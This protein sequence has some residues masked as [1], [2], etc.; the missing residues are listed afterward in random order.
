MNRG[1]D[2][3]R[4]FSDKESVKMVKKRKKTLILDEQFNDKPIFFQ[5]Q[6]I[7]LANKKRLENAIER[8][9]KIIE[10]GKKSCSLCNTEK[11]LSNF[12]FVKKHDNYHSCCK[13]CFA[14][15]NSKAKSEYGVLIYRRQEH[16][17]LKKE[18]KQKCTGC[19]KIKSI[20]EFGKS[21]HQL[22]CKECVS[23][24]MKSYVDAERE[25]MSD[26]YV[27]QLIRGRY[28][29]PTSMITDDLREVTRLD[30]LIRKET[31]NGYEYDGRKFSQIGLGRYLNEKY[32][33]SVA[34]TQ[35]R[36]IRGDATVEECLL[37]RKEY[38][39]LKKNKNGK[40][41]EVS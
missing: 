36:I 34:R 8:N 35:I 15:H 38:I 30:Y 11:D 9:K 5:D 32:G 16:E 29:I 26:S 7:E 22:H 39:K 40:R 21:R 24:D 28:N 10:N 18:G 13:Q 12:Y 17:Q 4:E 20:T 19:S 27:N 25:K 14:K 2:I 37:S 23:K 33:I 3:C 1:G 6:K 31:E 41:F